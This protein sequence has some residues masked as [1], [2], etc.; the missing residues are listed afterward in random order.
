MPHPADDVT[1]LLAGVS[2]GKRDAWDRLLSLVYR[3][4][5]SLAR[6]ALRDVRPGQTLQTTALVHEAY[7]R[8]VKNKAERWENRVHF[9]HVASR[10]M[11]HILVD[12]YRRKKAVKRGTGETPKPLEA[13]DLLAPSGSDTSFADWE[14]LDSALDKLS[15]DESNRRKCTLVELRFFVG[16]TNR[17]IAQVLD[18]SLAT[19]KRDWEFTRTWLYREMNKAG[20]DGRS[21]EQKD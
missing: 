10:A 15:A 19:I 18:V 20:F 7:I 12:S 13:V 1:S 16:L 21:T 2:A 17:E 5:R 4:L 14:A 3:E 11:R 9:F 8:L 6:G